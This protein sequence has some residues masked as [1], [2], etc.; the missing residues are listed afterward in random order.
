MGASFVQ[1]S[2]H[3]RQVFHYDL[4]AADID[5][6]SEPV[7][8]RTHLLAAAMSPDSTATNMATGRAADL[9]A[10]R[11]SQQAFTLSIM[12]NFT[13]IVYAATACVLV[14]FFLRPLKI[15]F[16]EIIAASAAKK[17]SS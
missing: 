5:R 1:F 13:L 2:L 14:V 12:D 4:L 8:S 11:V 3:H 17:A 15:G 6:G 10:G 9:F 16:R 7:I